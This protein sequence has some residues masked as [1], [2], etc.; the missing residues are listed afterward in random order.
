[1]NDST[2]WSTGLTVTADGDAV[3]AHAGAAALRL[4]ADRTGLTTALSRVLHRD[5]FPPA[6]TEAGC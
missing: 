5:G 4:T 6:M 1:V 2:G 3:I